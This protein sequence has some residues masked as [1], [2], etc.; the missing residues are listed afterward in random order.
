M[1]DRVREKGTFLV[2]IQFRQKETWQGQ[3]TWAEENKTVSFRSA[4]EL[5]RLLDE[6]GE[7]DGRTWADAAQVKEDR[8]RK[9]VE[10]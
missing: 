5:L 8:D 7:T 9:S 2:R 4:L 3:V 1:E 6:A 10:E